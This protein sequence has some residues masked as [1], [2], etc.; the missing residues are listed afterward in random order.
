LYD[1]K[2]KAL[3][4]VLRNTRFNGNHAVSFTAGKD[5]VW[6]KNRTFGVN[7]RAIYTGGLRATP[8]DIERS[9]E[10]GRTEYIEA[11]AFTDKMPDYFRT[12]LRFSL[13]RNM[14]RSTRT[15]SLDL[16]NATNQ[17]NLGGQYFEPRSGEMKKWY[18]LP[19]LPV[20]SY[21]VEF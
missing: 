9:K 4:G 18:Q 11:L 15:L 21:R 12:D 1:S 8:I 14:T 5:F 2:Y 17:R 20:L 16:Q 13:K 10:L 19:L 3:D 6:K 7:T